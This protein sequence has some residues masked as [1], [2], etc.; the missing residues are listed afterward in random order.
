MRLISLLAMFLNFQK[1]NGQGF[2][3][4]LVNAELGLRECFG[5]NVEIERKYLLKGLPPKV[6]GLSG[7]VIEQGWLPGVTVRK[8]LRRTVRGQEEGFTRTVKLGKG[9]RRLEFEEDI[10][11]EIFFRLWPQTEGSRVVKKR[12][13]IP[14]GQHTWEIDEFLDRDLHLAEVEFSSIDVQIEIPEWL[15]AHVIRE[16]TEELEFTNMSLAR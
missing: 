11:P 13:E 6:A 15:E 16:V 1:G 12:Y 5:S 4:S 2:F 3:K 8:R 14:E 9:L 7:S 10:A